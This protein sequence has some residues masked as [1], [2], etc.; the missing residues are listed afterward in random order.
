MN[1][2]IIGLLGLSTLAVASVFF[3]PQPI[4]PVALVPVEQTVGVPIVLE[5]P[6]E[7]KTETPIEK[8]AKATVKAVDITIPKTEEEQDFE[9]D[10]NTIKNV[11]QDSKLE[12][13]DNRI[14]N[15]EETIQNQPDPVQPPPPP[16]PEPTPALV[17]PPLAKIDLF[18]N[19][20]ISNPD[21]SVI[22]NDSGC[23]QVW[24][25]Q[26]IE[27]YFYGIAFTN[28]NLTATFTGIT[29]EGE[30]TGKKSNLSSLGRIVGRFLR[31][32]V[33]LPG[34]EYTITVTADS[35]KWFGTYIF[36][37]TVN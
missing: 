8:I 33:L 5:S 18:P 21:N 37:G 11:E 15:V 20:T 16:T 31:T 3:K 28:A 36:S 23:H 12:E 4:E 2:L 26:Q 32:Q 19:N 25:G 1:K 17:P 14:T 7:T 34:S 13:L 22:G 24:E 27:C 6:V 10:Q 29:D 9:I 35:D 30:V